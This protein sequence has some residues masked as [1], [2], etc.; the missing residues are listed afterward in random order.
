MESERVSDEPTESEIA[1]LRDCKAAGFDPVL[2][3]QILRDEV[4]KWIDIATSRAVKYGDMAWAVHRHLSDM[5]DPQRIAA[6]EASWQSWLEVH[7]TEVDHLIQAE[8][9]HRDGIAQ[10]VE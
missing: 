7:H 5:R 10:V 9:A 1:W 2:E 8:R 6:L 3:I 4:H